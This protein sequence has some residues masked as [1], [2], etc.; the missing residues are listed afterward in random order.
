MFNRLIKNVLALGATIIL[1]AAVALADKG[2]TVDVFTDAVLPDGQV[3]KAGE[4]QVVVSESEKEVQFLKKGKV[5]AKH[6]CQ[7]TEVKRVNRYNEV[8]YVESSDKKQHM[9]EIRFAGKSYVLN[10]DVKQGM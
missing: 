3:L 8:R 2:K 5:V 6:P 10:L 1:F 4:Y 9:T 7:S